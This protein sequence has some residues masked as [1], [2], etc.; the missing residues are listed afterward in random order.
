MDQQNGRGGIVFAPGI[1]PG[2]TPGGSFTPVR[3][4]GLVSW[5]RSD[6]LI[7][8]ASGKVSVWGDS[9]PAGTNG[10]SQGTAARQPT[11][12]ASGGANGLP[13]LDCG[14]NDV[15]SSLPFAALGQFSSLTAAECFIVYHIRSTAASARFSWNFSGDSVA[16][17]NFDMYPDA[18]GSIYAGFGSSVRKTTG[19]TMPDKTK[20]AL[21]NTHSAAN[22]FRFTAY[23][24]GTSVTY[25]TATNTVSWPGGVGNPTIPNLVYSGYSNPIYSFFGKFYE[26]AMFNRVLTTVERAAVTAYCKARYGIA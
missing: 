23:N 2:L 10:V 9:S 6:K 13:Y 16:A 14:A 20:I 21:V 18:N 8:L 11:Y 26:F 22:D 12:V 5:L 25:T 15:Y 24:N 4:P 3:L 19:L 17:G 1:A 7:T